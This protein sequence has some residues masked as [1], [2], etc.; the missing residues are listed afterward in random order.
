MT[1]NTATAE[2]RYNTS[3]IKYK[4]NVIDLQQ[5]TSNLYKIRAREYDAK[6]DDTHFI[7]YIAEEL[8]ECDTYFTWKNPDGSPEGIEWF[9]LLL[10]SI[11]EIK[12]HKQT[13][14]N[15]QHRN[16]ILEQFCRQQEQDFNEYKIHTNGKIEKLAS[17]LSQIIPK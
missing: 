12:Q 8:N 10:Y 16:Q 1:Y 9:N 13:I 11:E 14:D 3:S 7:G 5:D 4:K 6:I 2:I 15:L 17:I